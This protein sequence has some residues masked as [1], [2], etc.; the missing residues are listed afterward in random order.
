MEEALSQGTLD[1][2]VSYPPTSI[3]LLRDAKVKT[4][5]DTSDIP[6]EVVD[7]IA[8]DE[9]IINQRTSEVSKLLR[10]YQK[11]VQY[12][13]QN[14]DEAYRIM[15]A[16]EGITVDEF[17]KSMH[18]GMHIVTQAE[19][20]GFLMPGGK[21]EKVIDMSDRILRLT[22]QI[23]GPDRR[24]DLATDRFVINGELN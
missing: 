6:G 2:I 19:Q 12:T 24:T 3:K 15:S 11:A 8:V 13:Q 17:R 16:R 10:A 7:V 22:G 4:L 1:A 5:F 20:A 14:P 21:L 9:Q 23:N 18:D